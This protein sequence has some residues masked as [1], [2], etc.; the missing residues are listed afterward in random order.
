MSKVL[1]EIRRK[2]RG[3]L[4]EKHQGSRIEGAE[5]VGAF[6]AWLRNSRKSG[7]LEK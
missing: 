2:P 6:L 5:A 3:G 1:K 7:V 4:G